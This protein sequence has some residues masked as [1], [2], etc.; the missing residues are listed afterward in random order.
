MDA[1]SGHKRLIAQIFFC[2]AFSKYY[3]IRYVKRIFCTT[4]DIRE[5]KKCRRIQNLHK[6][7][8]YHTMFLCPL[9]YCVRKDL[10]LLFFDFRK[11]STNSRCHWRRCY[12]SCVILFRH[13]KHF[14]ESVNPFSIA[15]EFIIAQLMLY[16]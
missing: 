6:Q 8:L 14:C 16:K 15:M 7:L 2:S 4:G 1:A 13:V 5:S 11:I 9:I 3:G 12:S 10:S